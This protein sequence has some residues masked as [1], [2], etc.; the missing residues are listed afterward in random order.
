MAQAK[1]M[2]IR[3]CLKVMRGKEAIDASMEKL[4][5]GEDLHV[6]ASYASDPTWQSQQN[7]AKQP[8]SKPKPEKQKPHKDN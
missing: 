3:K 6:N 4:D 2:T 8:Q 7:G 1:N 5:E